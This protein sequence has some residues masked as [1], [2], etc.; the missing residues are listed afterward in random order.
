MGEPARIHSTEHHCLGGLTASDSR[1]RLSRTTRA[2][3]GH[4]DPV[5]QRTVT[6]QQPTRPAVPDTVTNLLATPIDCSVRPVCHVRN[7]T[8]HYSNT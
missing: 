7:R 8:I 5:G 1:S 3:A 4:C 2:V 6:D